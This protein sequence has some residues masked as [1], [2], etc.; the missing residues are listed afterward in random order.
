VRR[1]CPDCRDGGVRVICR[2]EALPDIF[3]SGFQNRIAEIAIVQN[4]SRLVF[5]VLATDDRVDT[6]Q[7]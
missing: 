3:G 5:P 1:M 4:L 2:G 6:V 7:Q